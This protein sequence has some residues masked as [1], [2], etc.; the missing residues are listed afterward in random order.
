[1]RALDGRLF[2]SADD[3]L[4]QNRVAVV[5]EE[6]WRKNLGGDRSAVSQVIQID[7]LATTII[8]V[9]PHDFH[10]PHGDAVVRADIWE[11]MR[12]SSSEA[13]VR[14]SN[15]LLSLGRLAP[16]ATVD[17]AQQELAQLYTALGNTYP[18]QRDETARVVRCRRTACRACAR[19][20]SSF[21]ARC[22]MV[23]L[24]ATTNVA[25][26]LL[27]RGV[28]RQREMAVRTAI[29]ASRW[30]V[31]RPVLAE[32]LLIA[33]TGAALGLG[34]ALVGVRTIGRLAV[35]RMPQLAGLT[36]DMRII[37][38]ALVVSAVVAVLCGAIP[39]WR[40]TRVDPQDALRGGRGGGAGRG[41]LRA[42]D[43]LVVVEVALSLVLLIGA[44]LTL[45]GF[46]KLLE[47]KP[48][49]DPSRMLLMDVRISPQSYVDG[50]SIRRFLEPALE[51]VAHDPAI[52]AAGSITLVPYDNWGNI[53]STSAM[54][55]S[56][57]T[58][59]RSARWWRTA[60]RRPAFFDVTKQRLIRGRMPPARAMR[61]PPT[62]PEVV[63]V[64]EALVTRDFPRQDPIGKRFYSTDTTFAT[65]V[66][67]VSNIKNMGPVSFRSRRRRSMRPIARVRGDRRASASSCA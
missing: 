31:M 14:N 12:F 15:Y 18:D 53:P 50:T 60:W 61:G 55:D 44:G 19:R 13:A 17:A 28:Q 2:T 23:L 52:E 49:F 42:L 26:L 65:I 4:G 3:D 32:S 36:V 27:A 56:R 21:S 22:V 64:N 39:A 7:G 1:M 47:N 63:L 29:G 66:G 45:K 34:L 62:A 37:A 59:H 41:H 16:G 38:F 51:A 25:S 58:T 9:L 5:S 30:D 35:L 54:R 8:G 46:T 57:T 24:I 10:V 33:G 67:V 48:G 43:M 6:F 40:A 20:S 11:P